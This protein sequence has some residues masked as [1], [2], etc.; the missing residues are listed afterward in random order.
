MWSLVGEVCFLL[1]TCLIAFDALFA[2]WY[3]TLSYHEPL[4]GSNWMPLWRLFLHVDMYLVY[5]YLIVWMKSQ[6]QSSITH[7]PWTCHTNWYNVT[8]PDAFIISSI[9]RARISKRDPQ[10]ATYVHPVTWQN[11]ATFVGWTEGGCFSFRCSLVYPVLS[12]ARVT[13]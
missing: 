1:L 7:Q 2:C 9:G 8:H 12:K 11:F 5:I 13:L 4:V 3:S 10:L 6:G